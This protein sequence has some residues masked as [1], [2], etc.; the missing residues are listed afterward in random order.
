MWNVITQLLITVSLCQTT[1]PSEGRTMADFTESHAGCGLP[2]NM[3]NKISRA[4]LHE[5]RLNKKVRLK[6]HSKCTFN[7]LLMAS[8]QL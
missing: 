4:L 7:L 8:R 5:I 1:Q 2:K 3:Y 6:V